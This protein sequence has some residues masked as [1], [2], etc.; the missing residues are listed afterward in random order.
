MD[1]DK[2]SVF[3]GFVIVLIVGVNIV[4]F[5]GDL[6]GIGGSNAITGFAALSCQNTVG[7]VSCSDGSHFSLKPMTAGCASDL[8]QVCTNAC[9]IERAKSGDDRT[10][11]EYC[12]DF[13]L[14]ESVAK[15][16]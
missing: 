16:L 14:P 2:W 15:N 7:G 10:C 13:C 12:A 11:P 4:L 8:K 5:F 1:E 9:E 3:I 6:F